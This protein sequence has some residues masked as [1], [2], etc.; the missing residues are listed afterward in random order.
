M[1][2]NISKQK[3][4][5]LMEKIQAIRLH[6]A[7][8]KDDENKGN[9]LTYLSELE[10]EIRSKKYGL[11]FEKHREG[12]DEL[13]AAHTPVLTE[14]PDLFI[15]NGGKM[16]FLIEGDNLA[17][18]QLLLKTHK[19]V[20]DL[21]YI[22]PPYNR[23]KND[24]VYDDDY[25]GEDDSYRHSKWASF[26]TRR[27]HLAKQLLTNDGVIFIQIDDNEQSV[28]RLICDEVFDNSNFVGTIIQNKLNS[29]N[30]SADIQKNHEY[31]H[32]YRRAVTFGSD[33]KP[34]RLLS[35]IDRL[36]I[37]VFKNDYGFYY[38]N[39]F[40][41]TRG[42]GGV[43]VNRLNLGQTVYYNPKTGD[44]FA[45]HDYDPEKAKLSDDEGFVYLTN[46]AYLSKGYVVIR[47]PKV[48]GKLGVWTWEKDKMIRDAQ[49]LEIVAVRGRGYSIKSRTYVPIEQVHEHGGKYFYRG[50]FENNV[51]S[52]LEFSTNDG[53]TT[54]TDVM[55]TAGTF[56]NPKNLEMM[57][58]LLN[59]LRKENP[60][61]LDFFAGSG[62][63]GHAVM[64]LNVED[65][66]D[67]QF[68]LC[69]NNQNGICREITYERLKRANEKE[70]CKASLKYYRIDYVPISEKLYYDYAD[71]LLRHVRELV[72]LENGI[73]FTSNA[74]VAIVLTD[75]ELAAFVANID[76]FKKC[77]TL[78][79]GQ[80]VLT[81]GD[82]EA[83][84]KAHRIKVN[85][86]P[87]YYYQELEA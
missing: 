32:V 86:I 49:L 44:F 45:E 69:T 25:V 7:R 59:R 26:M 70:G 50:A 77:R 9:L 12:I 85:I 84:L 20:I 8:S 65:K 31:I 52:V 71:E 38:L 47:P 27:L 62:T 23:G 79:L 53:T 13:L 61:I 57:M 24:F 2:T 29:K 34:T 1:S 56:D 35:R 18:L 16:N 67:R 72:E 68:I 10:K 66:G 28:L 51:K 36:D 87:E 46:Q 5:E 6:I 60:V 81:T 82:Q 42:E 11:V 19:G 76:D 15:N 48:R 41:T 58:Y 83:T 22:D 30:D 54:L 73:N 3:R 39:D 80:E 14:E 4:D 17:A 40:I 21:I 78:Y 37:E 43:L 33:G 63:T 64:R 75:E 74:K 55:G